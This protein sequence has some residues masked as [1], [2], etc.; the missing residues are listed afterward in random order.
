MVSPILTISDLTLPLKD[1]RK[2]LRTKLDKSCGIYMFFNNQTNEYY[3]GMSKNIVSRTSSYLTKDYIAKPP[4]YKNYI[5]DAII[6]YTNSAFSLLILELIDDYD[7]VSER[8]M[9]YINLLW[10]AYNIDLY[11]L[12]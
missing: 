10:P 3:I 2:I 8:E 7:Q 6:K 11:K 9:Y 4:K 12:A 5:K 1:I